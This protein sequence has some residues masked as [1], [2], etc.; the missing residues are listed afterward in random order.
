MDLYERY[1]RALL[2]KAERLLHSR[3]EAEDIVHGLF[4]DLLQ[5][6]R[7]DVG[8]PYL[9]RAVTHRCLNL[10]RD[11]KTRQRLLEQQEPA[12][13]GPVRLRC[14][15]VVVGLDLLARLTARLDARSLELL[16]YLYVDDMSQEEAAELLGISRRAVVKRLSKLRGEVER[17][18]QEVPA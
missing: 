8:L 1:G 14:E 6:Q 13:R 9:Y 18:K 17:L 5:Q 15:E 12:L 4:V 7:R 2:R 11:Q 3:A 10:L 16:V